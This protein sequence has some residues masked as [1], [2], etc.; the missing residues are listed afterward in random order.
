MKDQDQPIL[1][2]G[3]TGHY[4][5]CIVSSL[6]ERGQATRVL[7]RNGDRARQIL[8]QQVEI[9]KGDITDRRA[10]VPALVGSRGIVIAVSAFSPRQIRRIDQIEGDAVRMVLE[11]ARRAHIPRVVY[12]SVY[13]IREGVA[14]EL[15]MPIAGIKCQIETALAHS[16]RNW[17]VLGAA[18]SM[19]VFFAMI[20]GDRMMVPGG[21]RSPLPS[22]SPVD[23]GQIAAQTVMRNDLSGQRIRMV[24]PEAISFPEAARRISAVIGRQIHVREIPLLPLRFAAAVTRPFNPY[25]RHLV[26]SIRLMNNFPQDVLAQ[27][28]RDHQRLRQLFD[29]QPTTLE[30]EARRWQQRF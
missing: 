8:G 9:L 10:V 22:I 1:V 27:V 29:Y 28:E 23:V 24:G 30:M 4:G 5:R 3:G 21:G 25:L 11:E 6:R 16:D 17:T 15:D 19:Q 26:A 14:Q 13:D 18:P 7:S 2:L 12:I 20:R